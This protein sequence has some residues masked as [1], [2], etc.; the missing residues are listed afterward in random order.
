MSGCDHLRGFNA[1][2]IRA[3]ISSPSDFLAADFI[4]VSGPRGSRSQSLPVDNFAHASQPRALGKECQH[5]YA[6]D[7]LGA[8]HR[9]GVT[10]NP[11]ITDVICIEAQDIVGFGFLISTESPLGRSNHMVVC[12][13]LMSHFDA[14]SAPLTSLLKHQVL[15]LSSFLETNTRKAERAERGG[16]TPRM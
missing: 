7:E 4:S 15:S 8:K 1:V 11:T 10:A 14:T 9:Q 3:L 13:R 16:S 5:G 12:R 2:R 6:R